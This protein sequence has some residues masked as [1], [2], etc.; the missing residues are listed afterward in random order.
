MKTICFVVPNFPATSETFVTNQIIALKDKGYKVFVLTHNLETL[1][2]SNQKN[3]LVAHDI[4]KDVVVIDYDIADSKVK[5]LLLGLWPLLKYFKYWLR[6]PNVSIRH[7][8]IN[9]PYLLDFYAKLRHV[10]VFHIQFAVGGI[11]IAEMTENG[12]LKAKVITTFHGYDAHYRNKK[13]LK[14]LQDRYRILFNVSNYITV[15]TSYLLPKVVTLG[16]E[17]DKI[18][19]IPMGID[20]D[21]FNNKQSK[22]LPS[23]DVVKLISI[24]RLIKLKGFALAIDVVKSLISQ[25]IQVE[26]TIVGEGYL[27]EDLQGY[28]HKLGLEGKVK[29]VGNKNQNRIRELLET[30]HIYLMSSITDTKGRAEAQGIVTAE[31]QA[32]GLPVVAFDSGGVSDTI[33]NTETGFL[34]REKNVEDFEKRVLDLIENPHQY[35]FMSQNARQFAVASFS[36]KLMAERFVALYE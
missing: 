29:L 16:C 13:E 11:G 32:M 18:K 4:L 36:D 6:T 12:L 14:S 34:V 3:L 27:F 7:R 28:I 15:N 24:G 20:V 21:Y 8:F 35:Q 1:E 19:I 23:N 5:R 9:L 33:I 10:D 22:Q 17:K 2:E 31:A 30:S 25:G 26:Y